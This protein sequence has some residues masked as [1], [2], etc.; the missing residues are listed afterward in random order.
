MPKSNYFVTSYRY[1]RKQYSP[2][3]EIYTTYAIFPCK[4]EEDVLVEGLCVA[5]VAHFGL[6][7]PNFTHPDGCG[8]SKFFEW[9]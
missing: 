2:R 7:S 4:N 9:E 5:V 1:F 6:F 3:H 8:N